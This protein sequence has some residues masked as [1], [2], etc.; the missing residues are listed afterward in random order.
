MA[1]LYR[2]HPDSSY[3]TAPLVFARVFCQMGTLTATVRF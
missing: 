1:R 2:L 3:L